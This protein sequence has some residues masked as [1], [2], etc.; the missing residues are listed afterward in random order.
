MA[1]K[2]GIF[3]NLRIMLGY[4]ILPRCT[5]HS[6]MEALDKQ[7]ASRHINKHVEDL[8]AATLLDDIPGQDQASAALRDLGHKVKVIDLRKEQE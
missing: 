1:H 4:F 3:F 8:V 6:I 7:A 2:H 5:V